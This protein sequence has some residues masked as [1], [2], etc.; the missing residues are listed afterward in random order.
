MQH[1]L[2]RCHLL[3]AFRTLHPNQKQWSF[4]SNRGNNRQKNIGWRLDYFCLTEDLHTRLEKCEILPQYMGSDHCPITMQVSHTLLVTPEEKAKVFEPSP[5]QISAMAS[6]SDIRACP[7]HASWVPVFSRF[8]TH[9]ACDQIQGFLKQEMAA[10]RTIFPKPKHV[11]EAFNLCPFDQVSVVI[12]GQDPYIQ[13]NQAHGLAF[14]VK[15]GNALPPSLQNIFKE[16]LGKDSPVPKSL[17]CLD[18]WAKQGILL[19]NTVLTVTQGKSNSHARKGWEK[20]TEMVL[21]EINTKKKNVVF[22]A[23]GAFAQR[24]VD[25][26]DTSRHTVFKSPHP[27]PLSARSGFFGSQFHKKVN[28]ALRHYGKSAIVWVSKDSEEALCAVSSD[29]EDGETPTPDPFG[30]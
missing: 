30:F 25:K 17:G 14:S 1:I 3:D 8:F 26:I 23:W 10:K 12:V 24:W 7:L 9:S 6:Y 5:T 28:N 15:R 11:Y 18:V 19:L 22:V 13:M 27:S 2:A 4:W 21:E 20:L 16:I 29:D